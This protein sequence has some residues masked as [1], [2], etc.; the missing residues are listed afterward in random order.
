[1]YVTHLHNFRGPFLRYEL[2][3]LAT[4]GPGSCACGRGLPLLARVQGKRYPL[5]YLSDGRRKSAIT[6]SLL[7][8]KVGA[9]VQ[10]Q[11]IQKALDHVVV[12]LVVDAS[13]TEHHAEELKR[14]VQAFFEAPIRVDVEIRARLA[15]P[16]SGKFQ[17]M[18]NELEPSAPGA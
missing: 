16:A 17:N 7:V 2:G 3:D 4:V 1:V 9:H 12:N 15:L 18:I 11:A 14:K 10:H 6:L 8:R 5:F 13:W